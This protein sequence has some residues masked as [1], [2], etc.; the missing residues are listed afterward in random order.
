MNFVGK[1]W[2]RIFT[3]FQIYPTCNYGIRPLGH[4]PSSRLIPLGPKVN[5]YGIYFLDNIIWLNLTRAF[6]WCINC[7]IW[8]EKY[9]AL[10]SPKR[11]NPYQKKSN[12]FFSSRYNNLHTNRKP[13]SSLVE[14]NVLK[15]VWIDICSKNCLKTNFSSFYKKFLKNHVLTLNYRF[16]LNKLR[17]KWTNGISHGISLFIIFKMN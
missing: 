10:F 17:K 7:Y 13:L 11:W 6:D 15:I 14:I 3:K 1:V 16:W 12:I 8:M 5:V 4:N 2:R 9:L